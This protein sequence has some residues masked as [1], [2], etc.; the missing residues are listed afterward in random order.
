MADHSPVLTWVSIYWFSRAGPAASLRIYYEYIQGDGGIGEE[1]PLPT[2]AA[3]PLGLSYFPKEI[4]HYPRTHSR[5][6][7]NVLFEGEH[8]RGGH[9]AAHEQPALL[10]ADLRTMFGRGGPA[11]GVVT[12]ADGYRDP[13]VLSDMG[14]VPA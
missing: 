14:Y 5:T 8:K 3:L 4:I 2:A 12:G 10:V 7:G 9:F 1:K 11:Y 6:I 13:E